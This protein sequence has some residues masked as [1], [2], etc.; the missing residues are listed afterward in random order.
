M[1]CEGRSV[2]SEQPENRRRRK[3][4]SRARRIA[5]AVL[6][7]G[8]CAAACVIGA[9]V[10]MTLSTNSSV[11]DTAESLP[12]DADAEAIIILGVRVRSDGTPSDAMLDRLETGLELW[13]DGVAPTIVVTGANSEEARH[14]VDV[15]ARWLEGEGVPADVIIHDDGGVNTYDSMWR[16]RHVYHFE[17]IVAVS[18]QFHLARV[19]YDGE[20]QGLHVW[21]VPADHRHY[22]NLWKW[23]LREWGARSKDLVMGWIKPR[24]GVV[25]F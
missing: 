13:H 21:A 19:I 4:P 8:V 23:E 7:V 16:A 22:T 1:V 17:R 10:F 15:M 3:R 9:N 18:Q 24:A 11:Y 25:D 2:T 20:Q 12:V 5:V 6:A 14:Q